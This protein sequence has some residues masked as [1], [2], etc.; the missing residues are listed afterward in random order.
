[1]SLI[2]WNSSYSVG[3]SEIDKQHQKLVEII[4]TLFDAMKSGKA[5]DVM[6]KVFLDLLSYTSFHFTY[7]EKLMDVHQFPI[8]SVHK[9]EHAN[10]VKKVQDLKQ[11]A[12]SGNFSVSIDT[13][14]FLK[15][16]LMKHI[17]NVDKEFGKF[18]V[19]K[20]IK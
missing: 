4:N 14:N 2:T 12:A 17:Q 10:L 16:W 1:M 5:N 18:L 7:E 8:S 3:V 20:G 9:A 13:M 19:A 6:S 11:K 15:E